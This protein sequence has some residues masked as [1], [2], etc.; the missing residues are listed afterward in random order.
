MVMTGPPLAPSRPISS[1]DS[2]ALVV[3]FSH[4]D[5]LINTMLI[6]NC[7][8]SKILVNGGSSVN[9]LYR[10]ALDRMEDTLEIA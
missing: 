4:N 2:D 8:V 6:D 7:R 3:H 5:A 1:S 10:G 9:I